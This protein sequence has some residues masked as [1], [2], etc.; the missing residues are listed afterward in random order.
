MKLLFWISAGLVLYTYAGYP[1]LLA[2]VASLR[3]AWEDLRF[4]V[5]R[6]DRRRRPTG[7]S[8]PS[9]SLVF[10]AYNEEAAMVEKMRNLA[11]L[12]Y[13]LERLEILVGCDGCTD[14]TAELAR[15]ANLPNT[16]IF[17]FSERSGKPEVLNRLV[18]E[19]SGEIVVFSDANTFMDRGAV[20]SMA[21]R[22]SDPRV[23]CV[24]GELRLT[25]RRSVSQPEGLYWRYEVFL[26]FLESRLGLLLGANGG[27]YAIRRELFSPLPRQGVSDD[28]L[29]PMRI[30]GAGYR[31]IYD[32]EALAYE[33][34]GAGLRHDFRRRIRVGAGNFATLR[35]TA[36]LLSPAAGRLAFSYWSHKVFR[37]LAPFALPLAFFCSLALAR[38]G[39][40]F[41]AACAAV[42]A[43]LAALA[44]V[45]YRLEL[46]NAHHVL[47]SV[48]CYFLSMNLA[49]ML[50]LVRFLT[51]GH[52][53]AWYRAARSEPGSP[54]VLKG[55]GSEVGSD[56]AHLRAKPIPNRG[57][58][59]AAGQSVRVVASPEAGRSAP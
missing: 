45:G 32:P 22:F 38:L 55:A 57:D 6:R 13:P 15:A 56:A 3:Q 29:V 26:K 30:R 37:W 33:E 48:P 14:R 23:G 51:G 34:A 58:A 52:R 59:L 18:R 10:S 20:R 53:A 24:C 36:R 40:P 21:F 47:F 42:G 44:L 27:V 11:A 31:V 1:L 46:R 19:A 4:A 2:A 17:D 25:S 5:R 9:V 12:D 8:W 39:G 41:Y 35:Y 7:Q 54:K 49:M 43:T 50:G 16:R 28:F